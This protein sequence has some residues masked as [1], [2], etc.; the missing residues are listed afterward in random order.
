MPQKSSPASSIP[1]PIS[2]LCS[3]LGPSVC[4]ALG[5]LAWRRM[6]ERGASRTL[7][8]S[9]DTC[10]NN[11]FNTFLKGNHSL[12]PTLRALWKGLFFR[13]RTIT[14]IMLY[15]DTA[16]RTPVNSELVRIGRLR[17]QTVC[18]PT[19]GL[20]RSGAMSSEFI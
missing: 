20:T 17:R 2:I 1:S 12:V 6:L 4:S 5:T 11:T 19:H 10:K 8:H 16:S 3:V 9:P 15:W 13:M 7:F 14:R 18:G